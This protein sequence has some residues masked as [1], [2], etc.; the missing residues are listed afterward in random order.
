MSLPA[1]KS[2]CIWDSEIRRTKL[3]SA[4]RASYLASQCLLV[5]GLLLASPRL[6]ESLVGQLGCQTLLGHCH[7]S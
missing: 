2:F 5:S 7:R 4:L 1:C 6:D 3:G